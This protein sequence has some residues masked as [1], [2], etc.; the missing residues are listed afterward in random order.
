VI[1]TEDP[2]ERLGVHRA[3][4]HLDI[5][6]LLEEAASGNPELGQLEDQLLKSD[7]ADGA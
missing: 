1:G 5:E 7:H 2:Q 4:A 6:R 3:R